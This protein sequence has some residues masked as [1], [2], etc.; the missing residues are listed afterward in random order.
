MICN[1]SAQAIDAFVKGAIVEL[2]TKG[3]GLQQTVKD[4]VGCERMNTYPKRRMTMT[5]VT[6]EHAVLSVYAGL[7]SWDM[8]RIKAYMIE[9]SIYSPDEID[10]VEEE[11]KRFLSLV[12]TA[13]REE[14]LPISL[15]VDPFWHIHILHTADYRA[16][17]R[18]FGREYVSHYPTMK[19]DREL[20]NVFY[21]NGT[22]V[23]YGQVFGQPDQ[24]YWPDGQACCG[25][26]PSFSG[27]E[28][29][30]LEKHK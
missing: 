5:T 28:L 25:N 20:V 21:T 1:G 4:S 24:A 22:L 10:R 12:F 3:G 9:N 23:R 6:K 26:S 29:A 27:G 19:V 11:Y 30:S 7:N 13:D 15:Q 14:L 16:M 17:S 8:S 18:A 2:V